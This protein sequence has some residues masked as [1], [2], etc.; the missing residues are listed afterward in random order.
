[1]AFDPKQHVIRVRGGQEYLEVKWRLV[2]FRDEHPDWG[3]ETQPIEINIQEGRAI[4][5]ARVVNAEGR[6]MATGTKMETRGDFGDFVEKAETGAIGRALAMCGYGTQFAPE[7]AEGARIVDAPVQR[8]QRGEQKPQPA[9]AEAESDASDRQYAARRALAQL[10]AEARDSG[11]LTRGAWSR[12]L[13][14]AG[15]VSIADLTEEA[16]ASLC[17]QLK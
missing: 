6:L 2:W 16:A 1:M 11:R 7:L 3:I 9:P 4:F 8:Q 5:A 15:A 13:A 12:M 14:D 17:E 10:A